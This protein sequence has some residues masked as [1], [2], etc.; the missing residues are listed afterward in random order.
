MSL[1]LHC[2]A[3]QRLSIWDEHEELAA[4]IASGNEA[5]VP[6]DDHRPQA[7][8][9][10]RPHLLA[11][12]PAVRRA[13]D[14]VALAAFKPTTGAP[15]GSRHPVLL[16]VLQAPA[17]PPWHP[18]LDDRLIPECLGR[19]DQRYPEGRAVAPKTR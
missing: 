17:H 14:G 8:L 4:A 1:G 9:G 3:E 11:D 15:L 2:T 18:L 12:H 19:A 16:D 13:G 7:G 6:G 10:G 5:G